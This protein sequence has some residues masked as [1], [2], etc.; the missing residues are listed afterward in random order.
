MIFRKIKGYIGLMLIAIAIIFAYL[1]ETEFRE[2]MLYKDIYVLKDDIEKNQI[3]KDDMLT[4]TKFDQSLIIENSVMDKNEI[5]GLE[6]KHFI[7]KGTQ[8]STEYFD[9]PKMVLN[10]NEF[11]FKIPSDWIINY[12]TTIMSKDLV[13]FYP[14]QSGKD[15]YKIEN[16]PI[17]ISTVIYVKDSA[18]REVTFTKDRTI[19]SASINSIE[20]V[21]TNEQLNILK[22]YVYNGYKFILLTNEG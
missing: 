20:I 2:S 3:V 19:A 21:I 14:V 12:P 1:W 22:D 11:I 5:I 16:S 18:N 8:L 4:V 15:T 7:P 6:A 13:Y 10:E 9:N 17:V